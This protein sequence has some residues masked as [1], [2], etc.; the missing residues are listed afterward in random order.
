MLN[1]G[2]RGIFMYIQ[3]KPRGAQYSVLEKNKRRVVFIHCQ[4]MHLLN[5]QA[6]G[7]GSPPCHWP[8]VRLLKTPVMSVSF[9]EDDLSP[10]LTRSL[11]FVGRRHG[12]DAGSV[13]L[14]NLMLFCVDTTLNIFIWGVTYLLKNQSFMYYTD[15]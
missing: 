4:Q 9:C 15:R 8:P 2:E 7:Q 5:T 1:G 14:Q 6:G 3:Y 13:Y 11:L 10:V 12:F